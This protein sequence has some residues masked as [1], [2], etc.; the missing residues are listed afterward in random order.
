MGVFPSDNRGQANTHEFIFCAAKIW[1][2]HPKDLKNENIS[3]FRRRLFSY[4]SFK[5]NM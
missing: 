4:V 3:L 5:S 1:N 2:R